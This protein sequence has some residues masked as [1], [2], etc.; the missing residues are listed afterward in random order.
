MNHP[1]VPPQIDTDDTSKIDERRLWGTEDIVLEALR[2]RIR[3]YNPVSGLRPSPRSDR[4][5]ESSAEVGGSEVAGPWRGVRPMHARRRLPYER[6]QARNT[7]FQK[8]GKLVVGHR[9]RHDYIGGFERFGRRYNSV[10]RTGIM[11]PHPAKSIVAQPDGAE[12]RVASAEGGSS[13]KIDTIDFTT[14]NLV[15]S[16]DLDPS[17]QDIPTFGGTSGPVASR[18]Q[19]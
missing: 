16:P 6:C 13:S 19:G 12:T 10:V 7:P 15:S 11:E 14:T 17:P 5:G 2:E 3:L 18:S 4:S 8:I 9:R 1:S